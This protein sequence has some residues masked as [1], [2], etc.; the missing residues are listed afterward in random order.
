MHGT[1]LSCTDMAARRSAIGTAN[2]DHH[3]RSL[4]PRPIMTGTG[5]GLG[6]H[7]QKVVRLLSAHRL[8][9]MRQT[10]G[11]IFCRRELAMA[12]LQV[13]PYSNGSM[14]YS[15]CDQH[16]EGAWTPVGCAMLVSRSAQVCDDFE[17]STDV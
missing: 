15:F 9:S 8:D 10:I 2:N 4:R 6:R 7:Q 3:D 16:V 11:G 1:G 12:L 14:L 5:R 17:V 13:T